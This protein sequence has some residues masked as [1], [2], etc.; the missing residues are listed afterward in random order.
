MADAQEAAKAAA[1]CAEFNKVSDE[2]N[3]MALDELPQD[4]VMI[5]PPMPL[6]YAVSILRSITTPCLGS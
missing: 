3:K 4:N 5:S 6:P 2:M 1:L